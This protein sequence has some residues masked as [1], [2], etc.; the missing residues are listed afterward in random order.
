MGIHWDWL[1]WRQRITRL[2]KQLNKWAISRPLSR[3]TLREVNMLIF[4]LKQE[5]ITRS[6]QLAYFLTTA[7]SQVCLSTAEVI[8]VPYSSVAENYIVYWGKCIHY[9]VLALMFL[10]YSVLYFKVITSCLLYSHF[11]LLSILP[12]SEHFPFFNF[13]SLFLFSLYFDSKIIYFFFYHTSYS[14]KLRVVLKINARLIFPLHSLTF[15]RPIH[16]ISGYRN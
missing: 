5:P 3:Y 12:F 9:Y 13:I 8:I 2:G 11:A 15:L 6:V 1:K 16:C 10:R 14:T 7:F 4:G